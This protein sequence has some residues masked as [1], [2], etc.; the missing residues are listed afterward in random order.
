MARTITIN[1]TNNS[2]NGQ[3]FF[4]FQQPAQ[5]AGVPQVY[6]NSLFTQPLPSGMVLTLTMILQYYA[7]VNPQ[8][9]PPRIGQPSGPLA[10]GQPV[11]LTPAA[12]GVPT[13]NTTTMSVTP[14]LRLSAPVATTGP[15][16]GS[17]RIITPNYNPALANYNAGSAIELPQGEISFSNFVTARPNINL[18]C[19]PALVFYVETGSYAAG[20]VIDFTQSSA[21]AAPCDATPGYTTFNVTYNPSGTW[22]VVPMA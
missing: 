17:F 6:T 18:D 15:Q 3:D 13:A 22:T 11:N 10:V 5:Y 4:F 19:Q 14:S 20:T 1:V 21:H 7:G 2:P 8:L 9:L 16:P 12:G